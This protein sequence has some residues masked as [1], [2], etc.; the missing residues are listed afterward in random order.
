M[1]LRMILLGIFCIFA[2]ACNCSSSGVY[3]TSECSKTFC[4]CDEYGGGSVMN[5]AN[6]TLCLDGYIVWEANCLENK[7]INQNNTTEPTKTNP[8]VKCN[9]SYAGVNCLSD[10]STQ[11]CLCSGTMDGT[12]MTV[13]NDTVCYRGYTIWENDLRCNPQ[14]TGNNCAQ[15]GLQCSSNCSVTYFYCS[16]GRRMPDQFVPYGT[17]CSYNSYQQLIQPNQCEMNTQSL[18]SSCQRKDMALECYSQCSPLFYYCYNYTVYALQVAPEGLVCYD[19]SFVLA[20]E[21]MCSAN[22]SLTQKQQQFP[23]SIHYKNGSVAWSVLSQYA[24][25]SAM[26]NALRN[27]GSDVEVTDIYFHQESNT[28]RRLTAH[29]DT[30]MTIQSSDKNLESALDVAIRQYLAQELSKRNM[31][32]VVE[33]YSTPSSPSSSSSPSLSSQPYTQSRT[34]SSAPL[35]YMV[36]SSESATTLIGIIV[37]I[38]AS[39]III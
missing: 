33:F 36:S 19:N 25:A 7:N 12:L 31:D 16:N 32:I 27:A 15:D 30:Y 34:P 39:V 6:G 3:C 1:Y 21:P 29:V 14:F 11:Y 9:C 23:V 38:T 2:K 22:A 17:L 20:S 10:C 4:L 37:T 13:A 18:I 35:P 28:V 26:A 8:A 24:I 5:T